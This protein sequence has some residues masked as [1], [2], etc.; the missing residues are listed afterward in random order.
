[1]S[2]FNLAELLPFYLDET[3][4]NIAAL[5]DSL[6][7]LEQDPMDVKAL[8]E[9][10]RMFHS[11]KGASVVMGFQ[12]VNQL[13]HH[14][15]SL[16]EELRSKKREL[17]RSILDL[18]FRC[19]DELRDY[20][21]DLRAQGN[22][23]V[24]LSELV[25]QVIA[26]LKTTAPTEKISAPTVGLA[27]GPPP[28]PPAVK[29][30]P[31]T[32]GAQTFVPF[33]ESGRIS[34]TVFFQPHL[35]LADMKARLVLN[36][37]STRARILSTVP[38]VEQL[39]EID[40]LTKF[41]VYLSG[42]ANVDDLRSLA[43]VEGVTEI[44][45]ELSPGDT[46]H[47][48]VTTVLDES[49]IKSEPIPSPVTLEYPVTNESEPVAAPNPT[50]KT[51]S[52]PADES[53]LTKPSVALKKAKI[54][55]TIRVESDRLDHLMNLAGELVI[56][57]ARF[58]AI[59]RD[60]DELFRG[61]NARALTSDTRERLESLTRGLEGLTEIKNGSSV[62]SLDRWSVHVR[63]LRDNF[64]AIQDELNLI[65]EAREQ[66]KSLSETIHS[67]GRVSDGLQ[68][69]VLDTRMVPIGPLFERFRRVIRDLSLSSGKEVILQINGEKTELDKRMID[70]LSDPLIHMVRNA[71][72][73]GLEPPSQRES[74]GKPR[75]GTVSLSASHRGN[76]VV[77]TV[78]D[79]GQGI[80][81]ERIRTKIVTKGLISKV[82]AKELSE[83]DLIAF[84]W[85]PGLS[86]AETITEIS[87]RGVGMDIVKSRIENLS[88]TV[89]VR[90]IVG[91][92][93][94][95][96]IR[97]PLTLAIMSSL[98]VRIYDEIYAIPLDHI[99][100]IVEVRPSQIYRVQGRPAIEI[101]KKIVALVA[102][103]DVFRWGGK[104]HP[105]AR[106]HTRSTNNFHQST[107]EPS[108]KHTVVVVQN[109]ETTIGLLVDQLIGMQEVVLKSLEKNFRTIPGL[110]G[111]SILGDG[112]VSLILDLDTVLELVGQP[113]V[114]R[115]E[116]TLATAI[117]K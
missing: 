13:T 84:I 88:G 27:L 90:S 49:Q 44:Q 71:V 91:H 86:T 12:P 59:A 96:T 1:M 117:L 66:L 115:R 51:S 53:S 45:I 26:Y 99:D 57:K 11:I 17:D 113:S 31:E 19:L 76:S 46:L 8:Q 36:R 92:G 2:G 37:L 48:P 33:Q 62:A 32:G 23:S 75:A 107:D 103:G 35:P 55:E 6:L 65:R 111:A 70:E 56:T 38:S 106:S 52:T 34:L 94:T 105:S 82:D 112:R 5:N 15:E 14:L 41:T 28:S 25:S 9:A 10:F 68:K 58:V 30:N 60:L 97:L 18:T 79:D 116:D 100:E 114:H 83:R 109:G 95:F 16:F 101:R 47:A 81:C 73:H 78:S 50:P 69:G 43:D 102:L 61:S 24:D 54:V 40:P 85:H 93:T 63:Q 20:H 87:G 22:S 42:D 39:D 98:L 80:D 77:I 21:R 110:S 3:D 67:L 7:R 74:V 64:R 72:D 104:E 108:D 4:E 29:A 89:D